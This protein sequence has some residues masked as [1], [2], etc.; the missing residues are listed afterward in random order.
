YDLLNRFV[1]KDAAKENLALTGPKRPTQ[2]GRFVIAAKAAHRIQ[3]DPQIPRRLD[4]AL[5]GW[6]HHARPQKHRCQHSLARGFVERAGVAYFGE[7]IDEQFIRQPLY[8][9]A[10][11]RAFQ[12]VAARGA[13]NDFAAALGVGEE[14]ELLADTVTLRIV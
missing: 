5:G 8:V 3:G 4:H 1:G 10:I 9:L 11:N 12:E 13:S 6:V 7:R 2:L 14:I